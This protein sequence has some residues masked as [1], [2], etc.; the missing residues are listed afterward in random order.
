[1][2]GRPVED[3]AVPLLADAPAGRAARWE[4]DGVPIATVTTPLAARWVPTPG[5]HTVRL[6]IDGTAASS[7]RV[8]VAAGP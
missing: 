1:E 7:V 5:D 8:R 3:Q 6:V 4:V 2:T